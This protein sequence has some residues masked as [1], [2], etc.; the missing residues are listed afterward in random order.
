MG[1]YLELKSTEMA[2]QLKRD[3]GA[4]MVPRPTRFTDV[5]VGQTLICVIE[6]GRHPNGSVDAAGIIFDQGEL[7]R[8]AYDGTGRPRSW[9]LVETERIVQMKPNLA[10]Y[11]RGERDWR[12]V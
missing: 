12:E 1:F 5:P 11:L 4:Q 7:D 3:H 9:L 8:F 10:A 6:V 2:M